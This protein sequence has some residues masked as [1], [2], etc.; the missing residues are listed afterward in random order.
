MELAMMGCGTGTKLTLDCIKELPSIK[1]T[2]ELE[3]VGEFGSVPKGD[4]LE[5][6]HVISRESGGD[7]LDVDIIIGDSRQGWAGAYQ[8]LINLFMGIDVDSDGVV[9]NQSIQDAKKLNVKVVIDHVRSKGERL[10]GFGGVANPV[11]LPNTFIKVANLLNKAYGRQLNSVEV[12]SLIDHAAAAVVAGNV[13]RCLPEDALVHTMKGLI[14]IKDVQIGDMVQTPLGFRKVVNKF[15][16]GHQDVY[17]ISTNGP[18]P[19]A[20]LNHHVAVFAD[21]RGEIKWKKVED[22]SE[23][24]RLMH[25][26][27]IL[28]GIVTHLPEDHTNDRPEKSRNAKSITIPELNP[29]IAWLVGFTHGDGY[30]ALGRNKGDGIVSWTMNA[31][32]PELTDRLCE[33]IDLALAQFGLTAKRSNVKGENTVTH[34]CCSIRLTEYF[35]KNIKK[36]KECL[37]IPSF[38]LQGSSEVRAAYLA[39]LVDSDGY[40]GKGTPYLVTT[41]YGPFSRQVVAVLSSLGIAARISITN[42]RVEG[43]KLAYNVKIPAL[44]SIYNQIIAPHS[45]KGELK[46]GHKKYGFTL[47]GAMMRE[48]YSCKEMQNMGFKGHVKVDSNYERYV[49]EAYLDLDVPVTVKGLGSYDHVQTYDIEVED[50]HCFYCDGY[51]THNSAGMRQFDA[52]DKDAYMVKANLYTENSEGDWVVDKEKEDLR[53]AN[54]TA[55][56]HKMPT[57]EEV[58]TSVSNQYQT[59]EGALMISAWAIARVLFSNKSLQQEFA[60]AYLAD[61][62]ETLRDIVPY[63]PGS[64]EYEHY[65]GA[66]GLN[67][68]G[69][70]V[71]S[72]FFCNLSEIHLN[73]HDPSDFEDQRR[74]FETGA[75]YSAALLHQKFSNPVMQASREIDPIIGVSFTGLFDFFVNV[76]GEYWLDW[77]MKGRNSNYSVVIDGNDKLEQ[78]KDIFPVELLMELSLIVNCDPEFVKLSDYCDNNEDDSVTLRLGE[79]YKLTEKLYLTMWR[80]FVENKVSSYCQEKALKVPNRCTT[81]QPAGCLD[82]DALRVFD[83]GLLYADEIVEAGSGESE[84]HD[85][86]VRG[87]IGATTAIANQPLH[88]VKVTTNNGRVIRMTPNHRL[89]I[90]GQWVMAKD[91][92]PG[93]MIDFSLGEYAK[94]NNEGYY[95]DPD[96]KRLAFEDDSI[97]R[98]PLEVRVSSYESLECFIESM[99]TNLLDFNYNIVVASEKLARSIQQVGEAVGYCFEIKQ[100]EDGKWELI[101]AYNYCDNLYVIESVEFEEGTDYSFDFAVQGVDDDDSWYW[102]GAIKSHNTKSLLTGASSGWHPP[103]STRFIRRITFGKNDP[104]AMAA[105]DQGH[106]VIPSAK[107]KDEGG[108]L[109]DDPFDPCVEEWLVEVP[110]AVPWADIADKVDCDPSKFSA[111]AQFDFFMQVQEHYVGHATSGTIELRE[112]EVKP[113]S[114]AIYQAIE[115]GRPYISVALLARFD[116][117]QTFPRL[118]FEPISEDEYIELVS[119]MEERRD[120]E[121]TFHESLS[122][123]DLGDLDEAGP[124]GCDSDACLFEVPKGK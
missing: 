55:V 77:W 68:C 59:G 100:R 39:G 89:S 103:K 23:G 83:Q 1:R 102:Q 86:S 80:G 96:F 61:D 93:M 54:H 6:S 85:L 98:L 32:Q 2:V 70:I 66:F 34:R 52:D 92:K 16:Q 82:K 42:P 119:E 19:R 88:L 72:N 33:K 9:F 94:S 91:M 51:L 25:N 106:N 121:K 67:P 28:P 114:K 78:V 75:L 81:V 112:D 36:P 8:N 76:F 105:I 99:D 90:E 7:S 18:T 31:T 5:K 43:R 3:V 122:F 58:E 84:G 13:R 41:V 20:T 29:L 45:V 60:K 62:K 26:H 27:Q 95:S 108:K 113:L 117:N 97:D 110:T 104:V 111:V 37:T 12:C 15:D 115:D 101:E 21:A 57:Y 124:A 53:M 118:P 49:H 120:K 63:D 44:K 65:M 116:D 14:P 11:E 35:H 17:E 24:D 73:M 22:L 64:P 40:I 69:E 38:I 123:Y 30:V 87:G 10:K 4:R 50:A 109:L 107:A 56:F 74:S 48:S 79:L 47:S 46:I 71:G